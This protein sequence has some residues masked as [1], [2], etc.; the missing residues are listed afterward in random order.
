MFFPH[1]ALLPSERRFVDDRNFLLLSRH[2]AV[3]NLWL[4]RNGSAANT[5]AQ[6]LCW[7]TSFSIRKAVNNDTQMLVAC[8]GGLE[9]FCLAVLQLLPFCMVNFLRRVRP[10]GAQVAKP[11]P[12]FARPS[13]VSNKAS[14]KVNARSYCARGLCI[15]RRDHFCLCVLHRLSMATTTRK[16]EETCRSNRSSRFSALRSFR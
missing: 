12:A 8:I 9:N 10:S 16:S 3:N 5:S 2:D 7:Q 11:Q 14:S 4:Q 15:G 13:R 1:P 6:P